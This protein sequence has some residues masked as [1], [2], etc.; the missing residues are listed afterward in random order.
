M[1]IPLGVLAVAGAG[2]GAV[3]GNAYEHIE[4]QIL[5][6][7]TTTSVEFVSNGVWANYQ[8]LQLRVVATQYWSSGATTGANVRI[9]LNN[10]ATTYRGHFLRGN[11]TAVGSG[12]YTTQTN[13]NRTPVSTTTSQNEFGAFVVDILDINNSNKNTTLRGIGGIASSFYWIELASGAWFSTNAVTSLKVIAN[14]QALGNKSRFS[15]YGMRSS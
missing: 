3:A 6:N 15:L 13:W 11:G 2:G 9:E 10:S 12:E 7:N 1:P 14:E 5:S 4:T 8:H